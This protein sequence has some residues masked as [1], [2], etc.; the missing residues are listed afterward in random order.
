[1]L[2]GVSYSAFIVMQWMTNLKI[3]WL[4]IF[5]NADGSPELVENFLPAG[6]KGNILITSRNPEHQRIVSPENSS[7]V[8]VMSKD[9]AIELLLK[10]SGL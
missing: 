2:S 10:A 8:L 6:D 7:E 4:L 1:M 9:T 5:D 3:K